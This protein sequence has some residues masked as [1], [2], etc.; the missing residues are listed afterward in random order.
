MNRYQKE[1]VPCN[2]TCTQKLDQEEINN[3]GAQVMGKGNKNYSSFPAMCCPL[4]APAQYK[5]NLFWRICS[6]NTR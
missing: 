5:L 1:Y 6:L 3:E 2:P 4:G